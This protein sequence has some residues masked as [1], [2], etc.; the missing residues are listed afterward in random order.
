MTP[1]QPFEL[2]YASEV[3]QHLLAIERK[4]HSQIRSIIEEQLSYEPEVE[5]RN[6]KP[7]LRP[8][9]LGFTWELRFGSNNRFRVFYRTELSEKQVYILAIGVKDGNTLFIGGEE[10]EL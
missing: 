8:S 5:T 3:V 6:R 7:L 10:F 4:Y 2:I 1:Q 9:E